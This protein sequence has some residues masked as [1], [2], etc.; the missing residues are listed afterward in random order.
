GR[1][2]LVPLRLAGSRDR[3][4]GRRGGRVRVAVGPRPA[5]REVQGADRGVSGFVEGVRSRAAA[6]CRRIIFPEGTDERTLEAVARLHR[7][8]LV[9]PI[10]LG[11]VDKVRQALAT[12]GSDAGA[13]EV[14]DPY[15]DPRRDELAGLLH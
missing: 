3:D 13:I 8:G 14:A 15:R 9:Q 4:A 1:A 12:F 10:V 2:V 7:G 6:A 11:P 5:G